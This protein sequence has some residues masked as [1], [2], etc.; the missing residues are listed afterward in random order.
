MLAQRRR[1]WAT[2]EPTMAQCHVLAG[3]G[4]MI[5]GFMDISYPEL[6][7]RP[8]LWHTKRSIIKLDSPLTLCDWF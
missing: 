6:G 4:Y 1:R 7:R 3:Y 5:G 8:L 2:I